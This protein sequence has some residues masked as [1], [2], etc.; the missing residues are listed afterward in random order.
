MQARVICIHGMAED[1]RVEGG[2]GC[3]CEKRLGLDVDV[4]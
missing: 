2:S 1:F 3:S 4:E